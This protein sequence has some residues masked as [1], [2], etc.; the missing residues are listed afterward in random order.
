[1]LLGTNL[2][3]E[4]HLEDDGVLSGVIPT[5]VERALTARLTLRLGTE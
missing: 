1:M 3:R 5:E 4:R 2:T